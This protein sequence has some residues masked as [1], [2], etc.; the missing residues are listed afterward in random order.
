MLIPMKYVEYH[1]PDLI[2]RTLYFTMNNVG[3]SVLRE[4]RSQMAGTLSGGEQTMLCIGRSLMVRPKIILIDEPSLG[5][6]PKILNSVY[7]YIEKLKET[8][9]TIVLVEQ[10]VRKALT[11][12]D[13]VY[14]LALG[15]NV[16][17]GTP[18]EISCDDRL[19]KLYFGKI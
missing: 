5:L 7:K 18:Q 17:E 4:K 6:A 9:T 2:F 12:A 16:G 8:G 13:Y 10:N 3:N 11:V 15:R 19:E 1:S 14:V